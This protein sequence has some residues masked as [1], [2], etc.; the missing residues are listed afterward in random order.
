MISDFA[1]PV[2]RG[3]QC[4]NSGMG[5]TRCVEGRHWEIQRGD[6][7][8]VRGGLCFTVSR[9]GRKVHGTKMLGNQE[10][11]G[12]IILLSKECLIFTLKEKNSSGG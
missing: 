2:K 11:L 8:A 1:E 10:R 7:Q 9:G 12:S 3:H 5:M 6:F 4:S